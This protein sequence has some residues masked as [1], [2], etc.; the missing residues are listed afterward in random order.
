M[1]IFYYD[2]TL[3][4]FLTLLHLLVL[5]KEFLQEVLIKNLRIFPKESNLFA[6]YIPTNFELAKKFNFYLK[7]ILPEEF[8]KKIYLYYLCDTS[9]LEMPLVRVLR[10]LIYENKNFYKNLLDE[11]INKLYKAE[12]S[13]HREKH[14]FLGLL[15]FIELPDKTLWAKFAPKFNL[16]PKLWNH[17][18]RRFPKE[19]MI[20]FDTLRKLIFIYREKNKGLFWIDGLEI[21]ILPTIDPFIKLWQTYFREIAVPERKSYKRQRER[22][23]LRFRKFLPEFYPLSL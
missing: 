2:G 13:F 7:N 23:P 16:L 12:K 5:K 18:V 4:G 10:K 8:Y 20:I 21:E 19:N 3:E 1:K 14:R 6:E 22:L 15:R 11:D 17:F 9:Q